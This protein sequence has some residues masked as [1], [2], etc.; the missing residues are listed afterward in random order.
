MHTV[1]L[2]TQLIF[3]KMQKIHGLVKLIS[4]VVPNLLVCL[5][6]FSWNL[7]LGGSC[8]FNHETC[9]HNIYRRKNFWKLTTPQNLGK[10]KF[11]TLKSPHLSLF[12]CLLD[13]FPKLPRESKSY[14]YQQVQSAAQGQNQD[15]CPLSFF[16]FFLREGLHGWTKWI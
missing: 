14:I 13:C 15:I 16:L 2:L 4:H 5:S 10:P 7:H 6:F 12:F 11:N 1:F 3:A 9:R 8:M